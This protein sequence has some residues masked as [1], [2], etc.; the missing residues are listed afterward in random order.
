[1]NNYTKFSGKITFL[2]ST[3]PDE[4]MENLTRFCFEAETKN[5]PGKDCFTTCFT[6]LFSHEYEQRVMEEYLNEMAP[7]IKTGTLRY[8]S[9]DESV[10]MY[11]Y[12]PDQQEWEESIIKESVIDNQMESDDWDED[13]E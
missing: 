7:H 13:E 1:M 6:G 4:V 10:S 5:G 11:T 2:P 9:D 8:R 12:D 3:D